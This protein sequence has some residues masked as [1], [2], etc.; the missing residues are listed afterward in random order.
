MRGWVFENLPALRTLDLKGNECIDHT[1]Y[2]DEEIRIISRSVNVTCGIDKTEKKIACEDISKTTQLESGTGAASVLKTSIGHSCSNTSKVKVVKRQMDGIEREKISIA[3]EM[4][5][6]TAIEDLGYSVLD[7]CNEKVDTM[8]F[9][10]NQKIEFLPKSPH[11]IFPNLAT[12]EANSCAIKEITKMNFQN[13]HRLKGIFLADNQIYAVLS[14]TFEGLIN[15]SSLR[16]GMILCI[17][18]LK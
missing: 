7:P 9:S 2:K 5:D 12:Y 3:C 13:L 10:H 11:Q 8:D 14:D 17:Y 18:F 4:N 16:L 1:F 15:L 6:Y